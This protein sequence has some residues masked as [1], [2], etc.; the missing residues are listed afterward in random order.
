[1]GEYLHSESKELAYGTGSGTQD[2]ARADA[3]GFKSLLAVGEGVVSGGGFRVNFYDSAAGGTA[4]PATANDL[5]GIGNKTVSN[6]GQVSTTE[7]L[8]PIRLGII[9][10]K[11]YVQ[12]TFVA[13][14]GSGSEEAWLIGMDAVQ[15]PVEDQI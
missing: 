7:T 14:G 12:L 13:P 2:L 9:P 6:T 4:T 1:M 8:S 11:R 3:S 5:I 10:R 15:Q